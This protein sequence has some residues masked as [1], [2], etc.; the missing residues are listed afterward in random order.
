MSRDWIGGG[1]RIMF[2]LRRISRRL[3]FQRCNDI[4]LVEISGNESC[5]SMVI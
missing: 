4:M 2:E 1:V 5:L 3:V